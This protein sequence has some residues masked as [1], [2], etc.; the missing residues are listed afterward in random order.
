MGYHFE[1]YR[2]RG[3]SDVHEVLEGT[4]ATTG[5]EQ[6]FTL[7]VELIDDGGPGPIHLAGFDPM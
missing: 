5:P 3:A 1:E 4:T 7:Y 2:V 6:T